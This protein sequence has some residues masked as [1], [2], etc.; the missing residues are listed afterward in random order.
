MN[1]SLF[2]LLLICCLFSCTKDK[3]IEEKEEIIVPYSKFQKTIELT[4]EQILK[5]D[6]AAVFID[7][8][9]TLLM[10]K[11]KRNADHLY[12]LY[13]SIG[14][15]YMGAVGVKGD[16][17]DAWNGPFLHNNQFIKEK[18]EIKFWVHDISRQELLLVNLTK[19]LA[20]N[21]S[22]PVIESTL[23]VDQTKFPFDY[24]YIHED[25]VVYAS[26]GYFDFENYIIKRIDLK[27]ND[28][29]YSEVFPKIK[30][31]NFLRSEELVRFYGGPIIK[32]PSE[33]L[34]IDFTQ[35]F[36]RINLIGFDLEL[37][38]S[39]VSGNSWKDEYYDGE[40]F[41]KNRQREGVFANLKNYY[42]EGE[43]G[44]KYSYGLFVDQKV[45]ERNKL[46]TDQKVSERSKSIKPVEIRVFDLKGNA[47]FK[48]QI[49]EYLNSFTVD[50]KRGF[51]YGV[52]SSE[53]K[54][55]RYDISEIL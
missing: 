17:P 14:E 1:K 22:V 3:E 31:V 11:A 47:L 25:S 21:Q 45:S 16:R 48:L 41:E 24:A 37:K 44:E 36:N 38:L 23:K 39:I 28:I 18:G 52:S 32:H 15:K 33:E 5:Q 50:E 20:S 46:F 51:I 12:Y 10:V 35:H 8:I 54:I 4:G 6:R 13:G 2:V 49:P 34:F 29:K 42:F 7:L 53:E 40:E 26:P 27:T 9:D 30:N 19:T 55:M 43:V